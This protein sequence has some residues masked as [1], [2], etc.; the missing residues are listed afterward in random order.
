MPLVLPSACLTLIS[1]TR[2]HAVYYI[3]YRN[4]NIYSIENTRCT[5]L[6]HIDFRTEEQSRILE[7]S[8][9]IDYLITSLI[10]LRP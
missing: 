9:L 10:K 3:F 1:K 5:A 4:K 8:N 7:I 6:F 2:T